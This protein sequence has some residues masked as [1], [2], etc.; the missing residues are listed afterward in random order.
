M[1]NSDFS[2]SLP[3]GIEVPSTA[4]KL[5]VFL[6]L[7]DTEMS[8][9]GTVRINAPLSSLNVKESASNQLVPLTVFA[10]N[11]NYSGIVSNSVDSITVTAAA[12]NPGSTVKIN[13]LPGNT[14]TVN[15]NVGYNFIPIT[16]TLTEGTGTT[17]NQYYLNVTRSM[18]GTNAALSQLSVKENSTGQPV[19]LNLSSD[20]HTYSGTVAN[21]VYSI[22]VAAVTQDLHAAVTI[23]GLHGKT[24][25]VN[26]NEGLNTI[27]VNVTAE[28]GTT[29]NHYSLHITRNAPLFNDTQLNSLSLGG[30]YSLTPSFSKDIPG[31]MTFVDSQATSISVSASVYSGSNGWVR[32]NNGQEKKSVTDTVYLSGLTTVVPITIEAP[33]KAPGNYSITVV[34]PGILSSGSGA[35]KG[36][37]LEGVPA[38]TTAGALLNG[39]QLPSGITAK[40]VNG[41]NNATVNDDVPVDSSMKVVASGSSY[42]A[43][44]EIKTLT[45][46]LHSLLGTA[47]GQKLQVDQI[48]QFINQP[49]KV[50]LTGDAIFN[51]KDVRKVLLEITPVK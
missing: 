20:L 10:D 23:N 2:V 6:R 33:G 42:S 51:A 21:S 29:V 24:G 19:F 30:G 41:T 40:V 47:P 15:L 1:Y 7:G 5:G 38:G 43:S 35:V 8:Y 50:D 44:Y 18:S 36:N 32:I 26:L 9:P 48:L 13:N 39:L 28:N 45:D 16:V 12:E 3:E 27:P 14:A 17:I 49:N 34:K 37:R 46:M 22:N 11:H 25:D 31:Y 4:T